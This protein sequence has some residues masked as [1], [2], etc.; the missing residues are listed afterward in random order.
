MAR[1][2]GQEAVIFRLQ[3]KR[4]EEKSRAKQ[5][6]SVVMQRLSYPMET[7]FFKKI[8]RNRM[9]LSYKVSPREP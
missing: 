4:S 9:V 7:V 3:K 8:T 5:E 6:A 1:Q 2:E